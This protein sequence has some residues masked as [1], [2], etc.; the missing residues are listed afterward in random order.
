MY[1]I[2]PIVEMQNSIKQLLKRSKEIQYQQIR[3]WYFQLHGTPSNTDESRDN[4][5]S[6]SI[7]TIEPLPWTSSRG[8]QKTAQLTSDERKQLK[9]LGGQMLWVASQT[10]PDLRALKHV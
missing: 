10:R 9:R 6:R 4:S 5:Q 1:M 3:E 7:N 8:E 2:L